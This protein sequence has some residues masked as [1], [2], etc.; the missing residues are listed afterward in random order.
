VKRFSITQFPR[1][2]VALSGAA[3]TALL[4]GGQAASAPDNGVTFFD[5]EFPEASWSGAAL[6]PAAPNFIVATRSATGGIPG[7]YRTH[8]ASPQ[9]FGSQFQWTRSG[10]TYNPATQGKI[11]RVDFSLH[12]LGSKNEPFGYSAGLSILLFQSGKVYQAQSKGGGGQPT[13]PVW[14]DWPD[15]TNIKEDDWWELGAD[16]IP[17]GKGRPD[18]S[19]NGALIQFGYSAVP[20]SSGSVFGIDNLSIRIN[21]GGPNQ[22]LAE[23]NGEWDDP[24]EVTSAPKGKRREIELRSFTLRNDGEGPARKSKLEVW[25]SADDELSEEDLKLGRVN[26]PELAVAG[27]LVLDLEFKVKADRDP[28]TAAGK[29]L[30]AVLDAKSAVAESDESNNH[31]IYGPLP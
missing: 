20:P 16:G 13:G 28:T 4:L 15:Q 9:P 23:L 26:I 3:L 25:L 19:K 27:T 12:V 1:L 5:G 7:A 18:F 14:I 8:V 11:T 2:A 31:V 29:H 22:G 21:G 24:L 6:P 10:W 30:I 17:A